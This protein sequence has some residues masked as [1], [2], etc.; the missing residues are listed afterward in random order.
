[1]KKWLLAGIGAALLFTQGFATA[2][3]KSPP[4]RMSDETKECVA[5]HKKNNPG[6]VQMW[7]ASKHYGA[8]VGCYECHAADA[9]DPDAFIHDD[10]K[11][12]KNISIIVSPKDCSN[13]HADEAKEMAKSHHAE[14][15]KIMGSLDN[16]LAE[17]IEGDNGMVT[18]GFPKG[19]F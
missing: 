9:K 19:S 4:D 6:L 7:G 3:V 10:K 8:N 18:P 11:V 14:A 12:K 1:M 5:C 16:L 13:C 2:S 17:V 15:G